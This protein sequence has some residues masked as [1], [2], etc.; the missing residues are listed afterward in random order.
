MFTQIEITKTIDDKSMDFLHELF[1][2]K[3]FNNIY[4]KAE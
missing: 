4:N 3:H 2:I 1:N